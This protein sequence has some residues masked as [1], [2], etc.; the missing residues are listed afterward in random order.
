[1]KLVI[2]I[3]EEFYDG[4]FD[5]SYDSIRNIPLEHMVLVQKI[6]NGT[7]LPKV[8]GRLI[9]GDALKDQMKIG[10]KIVENAPTIIEADK[11]CTDCILDGTDA[12]PRGAG[13]AV[14]AE[15][16]EDFIG[17]SEGKE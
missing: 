9:D 11:D 14:D 15:V 12:C 6:K 3:S 4:L 16:C 5:E 8:H 1:M 2:D 7:P 10:Y 13:R 17:E